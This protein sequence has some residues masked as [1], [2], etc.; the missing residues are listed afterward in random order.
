MAK[1]FDVIGEITPITT[2][3]KMDL[4]T[5]VKR[6][7]SGD[8]VIADDDLRSVW[9]SHFEMMQELGNLRFERAVVSEDAV[10]LDINTTDATDASNKMAFVAIY[11]RFVRRN[12]TYSCQL[13]FS[14]SKVVPD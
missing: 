7:L 3:M 11:A 10:N 14:R 8:D 9:V 1:I 2:A 13:V 12:G 5:L 4:H 6:G